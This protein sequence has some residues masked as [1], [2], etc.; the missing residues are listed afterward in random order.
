MLTRLLVLGVLLF[1]SVDA[2]ATNIPPCSK[3]FVEAW[4]A[5]NLALADAATN[6]KP[7]PEM[8]P[9]PKKGC[10]LVSEN[11]HSYVC[12]KEWRGRGHQ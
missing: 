1:Y 8:P 5:F 2:R 12:S 11:Y 7:E 4:N 6:N 9:L 3:K 10:R